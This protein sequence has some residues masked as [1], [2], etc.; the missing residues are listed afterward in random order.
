[1]L[2]YIRLFG[3]VLLLSVSLGSVSK[4]AS[5][6]CAKATTE[7]EIAIC[8]DPELSALDELMSK[9]YSQALRS[10]DW[11]YSEE[12]KDD[13]EL[14]ASQRLAIRSQTQC[15]RNKFCL[16]KF[17][18]SR[19]TDILTTFLYSDLVHNGANP[20]TSLL[21]FSPEIT[22]K[23]SIRDLATSDDGS[24][25]VLMIS[26]GDPENIV[27]TASGTVYDHN[28]IKLIVSYMSSDGQTTQQVIEGPEI[29]ALR[30]TL[31]VTANT[32]TI[33]QE[34]TRG[35]LTT[36]YV[37][38]WN[39][40]W[41]IAYENYS[42]VT[43]PALGL[44]ENKTTDYQAGITYVKYSY[45]FLD[46]EIVGQPTLLGDI[47]SWAVPGYSSIGDLDDRDLRKFSVYA[48]YGYDFESAKK[49]F[50]ILAS[51]GYAQSLDDLECV[52]SAIAEQGQ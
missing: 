21:K 10:N 5:F 19:I 33:D 23:N 29:F 36:K 50:E 39:D 30:S 3:I 48:F 9:L 1:M 6:D 38:S 12:D 44:L 37:R 45:I 14:I 13:S 18:R 15:D 46:C 28:L 2:Q 47:G 24:V 26:E 17:Y 31:N 41:E 16:L 40:K 32:F 8:S 52:K 51:R 27:L 7:T 43:R 34:H 11:R 4:A 20:A 49:G 35:W 42:G 22:S 25:E